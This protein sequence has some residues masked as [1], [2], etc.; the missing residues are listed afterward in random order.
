MKT[1]T[2]TTLTISWGGYGLFVITFFVLMILKLCGVCKMGWIAISAFL[3]G[4]LALLILFLAV[5]GVIC[6]IPLVNRLMK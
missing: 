5:V 4:P 6:A 2:V 1:E 3:W